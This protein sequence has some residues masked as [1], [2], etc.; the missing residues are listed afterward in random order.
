MQTR[1]RKKLA[2][3]LV[4]GYRQDEDQVHAECEGC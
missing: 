4:V 1:S 3:G 2:C